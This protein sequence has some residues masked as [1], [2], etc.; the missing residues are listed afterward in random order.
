MRADLDR[1]GPFG[2]HMSDPAWET[3]D[4]LL[5]KGMGGALRHYHLMSTDAICNMPTPPMKR[6]SVLILWRIGAMAEDAYRVA[7]AWGFEP[8]AEI[9]WCKF[10]RCGPCNG[11]GRQQ[12]KTLELVCDSCHGLGR[13]EHF[14][15]GH[16][17]RY[18][19]ETAIIATRGSPK[20]ISGNV[21]STFD[22]LMP[23]DASGN[24]IHSAKPPEIYDLLERLYPGP[25][26]ETFARNSRPGWLGLGDQLD[27]VPRG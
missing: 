17:V 20:R 18:S 1:C 27:E 7:R 2:L 22:A 5:G 4:K 6:D 13:H 8:K 11:T 9:V 16:S 26:V 23:E 21:R 14:G 3:R 19:H 24:L 25:Y 10:R 15:M 12:K